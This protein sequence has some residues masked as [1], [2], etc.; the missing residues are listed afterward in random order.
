M[1]NYSKIF[2][3][4]LKSYYPPLYHGTSL[5]NCLKILNSGEIQISPSYKN[6][7]LTR[8]PNLWYYDDKK[9]K[10]NCQFVI[11][12]EA[13]RSNFKVKPYA[14]SPKWHTSEAEFEE[15]V[16]KKIPI[17]PKYITSLLISRKIIEIMNDPTT[18]KQTSLTIRLLMNKITD[19]A[20]ELNIQIDY[21]KK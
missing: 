6:I 15:T 2:E 10:A 5:D 1:W 14:F 7:S 21:V 4:Y 16:F 11:N 19:K 17:I 20:K 13:L 12:Q 18:S 3:L 9:G 8:D